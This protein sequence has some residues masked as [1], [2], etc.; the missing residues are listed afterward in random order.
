MFQEYGIELER[1][2]RQFENKELLSYKHTL[3]NCCKQVQ[4]ALT[5]MLML[6]LKAYMNE[7]DY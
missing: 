7:L 6:H 5:V 4:A 1:A 3:R 2:Y